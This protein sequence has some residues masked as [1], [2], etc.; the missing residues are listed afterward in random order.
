MSPQTRA[1]IIARLLATVD[2]YRADAPAAILDPDPRWEHL[3]DDG[4]RVAAEGISDLAYRNV[5]LD[6][7]GGR[8]RVSVT[9]AAQGEFGAL[10]F[11]SPEAL[12]AGVTA[13]GSD[14]E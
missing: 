11:D 14:P 7:H 4:P 8:A 6:F 12:L 5:S 13:M 10:E 2:S 9:N 1:E 3:L